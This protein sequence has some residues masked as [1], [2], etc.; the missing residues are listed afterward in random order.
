MRDRPARRSLGWSGRIA[1][2]WLGLLVLSVFVVPLL[3]ASPSHEGRFTLRA[4]G[5]GSGLPIYDAL[6]CRD[7]AAKSAQA[8][9]GK[10][11]GEFRHLLGVDS[12]GRARCPARCW[13]PAPHC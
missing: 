10:A 4:C 6:G 1:A 8:E 12:A 11:D 13:A 5:D 2:G 9:T 7:I 3:R